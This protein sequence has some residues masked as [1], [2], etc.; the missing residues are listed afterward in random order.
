MEAELVDVVVGSAVLELVAEL[1]WVK[2]EVFAVPLIPIQLGKASR[3]SS[4]YT[5]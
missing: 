3:T 4:G 2:I 5:P 1:D